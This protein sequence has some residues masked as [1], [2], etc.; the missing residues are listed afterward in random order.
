[1]RRSTFWPA[2]RGRRH[3]DAT[4]ANAA[5]SRRS[6]ERWHVARRSR[7]RLHGPRSS[8][9]SSMPR[10]IAGRLAPGGGDPAG[11]PQPYARPRGLRPQTLHAAPV[12]I[13]LYVDVTGRLALGGDVDAVPVLR[14]AWPSPRACPAAPSGASHGQPCGPQPSAPSATAGPPKTVPRPCLGGGTGVAPT[15]TLPAPAGGS[16]ALGA[17]DDPHRPHRRRCRRPPRLG[18]QHRTV[19]PG[20][21]EGPSPGR[22]RAR[23]RCRP[24]LGGRACAGGARLPGAPLLRRP[25]RRGRP[26]VVDGASDG[27]R[28]VAFAG[29][30]PPGAGASGGA[31]LSC[32]AALC[33]DTGGSGARTGGSGLLRWVPGWAHWAPRGVRPPPCE[34]RAVPGTRRGVSFRA[35]E[36]SGPG[37]AAGGD[38]AP[39]FRLNMMVRGHTVAAT[40]WAPDTWNPWWWSFVGIP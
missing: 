34:W 8:S 25:R 24:V 15:T 23:P 36:A 19:A 40:R 37:D 32:P 26:A 35:G 29:G 17:R 21:G 12:S 3:V 14:G 9:S 11:G 39:S 5:A 20:A 22:G 13:A 2:R 10:S 38:P 4:P 33:G 27:A 16:A 28:G 6:L 18:A 31:R 1:M 30:A 7:R